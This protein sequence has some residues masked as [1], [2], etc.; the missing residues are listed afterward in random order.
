VNQEDDD[1]KLRQEFQ[2]LRQS[3]KTVQLA[4]IGADGNPQASYAPYVWIESY[5]YLYLSELARHTRNL[6]ANPAISLLLI[7]AEK[8]SNNLFARQRIIL[9]AKVTRIDRETDQFQ[10]VMA[11]FKSQFGDFI[12]VIE[13]LQ[14]FH[15]FQIKPQS[16]RFI[17]GFAQAYDLVGPGLDELKH[18]DTR[19]R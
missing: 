13:P 5:Y 16:G 10:L 9:Q 19:N 8:M 11:E 7:E 14:D 3:L 4:T 6:I 1:E 15:L 18:I 17:R 2:A 12:D